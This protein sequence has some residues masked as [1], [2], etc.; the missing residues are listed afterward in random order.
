MASALTNDLKPNC[1][2]KLLQQIWQR[3]LLDE[4]MA[5]GSEEDALFTCIKCCVYKIVIVL[6][7]AVIAKNINCLSCY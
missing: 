5:V 3:V 1:L 6:C 4:I 2:K 7:Q